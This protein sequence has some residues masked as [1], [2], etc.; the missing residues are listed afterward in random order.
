MRLTVWVLGAQNTSSKRS[1][2]AS[3]EVTIDS[4]LEDFQKL[5][6]CKIGLR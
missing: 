6:R 2:N 3:L 1:G 4:H 5:T